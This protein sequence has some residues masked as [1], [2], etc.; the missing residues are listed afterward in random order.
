MRTMLET[1]SKEDSLPDESINRRESLY[2]EAT[3]LDK[4]SAV[5]CFKRLIEA[6]GLA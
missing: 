6:T 5:I 1:A 3:I 4:M 2:K